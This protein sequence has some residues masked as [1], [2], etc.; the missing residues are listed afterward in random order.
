MRGSTLVQKHTK[1]AFPTLRPQSTSWPSLQRKS[2]KCPKDSPFLGLSWPD[3][4]T[5]KSK[6]GS[7]MA[8]LFSI[9][10][11]RTLNEGT[12]GGSSDGAGGTLA[13]TGSAFSTW[14]GMVVGITNSIS[15]PDR[16]GS[17]TASSCTEGSLRGADT[18][19]RG[20]AWQAVDG[21]GEKGGVW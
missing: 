5:I 1:I 8:K 12:A 10:A 2:T 4:N 7:G 6:L 16:A 21:E 17:S 19:A 11:P 14:M 3:T 15:L 13:A 18:L 20:E 9:L